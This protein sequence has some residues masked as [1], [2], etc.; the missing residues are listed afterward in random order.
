MRV[1]VSIFALMISI[2][3]VSSAQSFVHEPVRVLKH[4]NAPIRLRVARTWVVPTDASDW[5]RTCFELE[6]SVLTTEVIDSFS[7]QTGPRGRDPYVL[8]KMRMPENGK[9]VVECVANSRDHNE[10]E[11]TLRLDFVEGQGRTLWTNDEHRK[12][13]KKFFRPLKKP[14]IPS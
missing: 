5:V 10:R 11:F 8:T 2:P 13:I 7:Y 3:F 4:R 6:V 9:S 14:V 1:L 12:E